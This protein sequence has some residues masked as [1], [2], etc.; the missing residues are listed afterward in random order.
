MEEDN[1]TVA[2]DGGGR[3]AVADGSAASGLDVGR[4]V[5]P[6]PARRF[7]PRPRAT[8]DGCNTSVI[9][10]EQAS[11]TGPTFAH[12]A[13]C[14]WPQR[15]GWSQPVMKMLDGCYC[16]TSSLS[17]YHATTSFHD[18]IIDYH[19]PPGYTLHYQS[20]DINQPLHPYS[21]IQQ[22]HQDR[23]FTMYFLLNQFFLF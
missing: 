21:K 9:L 13:P 18:S 19:S 11:C 4:R 2:V 22:S 3:R 7:S 8:T 16:V 23:S 6:S 14:V 5:A 10:T 20:Q 12:R 15:I 17:L 1:D